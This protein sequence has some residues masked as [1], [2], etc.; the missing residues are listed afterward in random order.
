MSAPTGKR[1]QVRGQAWAGDLVVSEVSV[2][3]DFGATWQPAELADP[4]NR[5]AWQQWRAEVDLPRQGYFELW[6]RATD[7]LGRAQPMLVPG[8][9]P[10]GYLNNAS[11]RIALHAV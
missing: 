10:K 1:L 6:A 3:L 8:W 7:E 9:N 11:H 4:V 2:S 5:L